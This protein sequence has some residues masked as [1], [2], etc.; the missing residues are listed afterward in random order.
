[1]NE[2][3]WSQTMTIHDTYGKN[4]PCDHHMEHLIRLMKNS[5]S[6]LWSNITNEAVLAE[7]HLGR[8]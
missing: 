4:I 3:A 6:G 5:I 8:Q 7:M 2:L 1:M